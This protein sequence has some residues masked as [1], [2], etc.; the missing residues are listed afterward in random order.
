LDTSSYVT[1]LLQT[2]RDQK[3]LCLAER[4]LRVTTLYGFPDNWS[5]QVEA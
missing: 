4:R 2:V 3:K 5:G 1:F